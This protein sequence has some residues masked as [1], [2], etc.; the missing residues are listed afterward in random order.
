MTYEW[1]ELDINCRNHTTVYKLFVLYR[2]AYNCVQKKK[3]FKKQLLKNVTVN[4]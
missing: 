2:N 3:T 4:V 1:I